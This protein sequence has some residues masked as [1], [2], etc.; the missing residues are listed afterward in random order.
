VVIAGGDQLTEP[1]VF[2]GVDLAAGQPLVQD[3]HRVVT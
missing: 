1:P 2:V 3:A